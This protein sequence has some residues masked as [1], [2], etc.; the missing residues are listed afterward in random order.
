M[1]V[2]P[3]SPDRYNP[4]LDLKTAGQFW[5]DVISVRQGVPW[6]KHEGKTMV[7]CEFA[8][9]DS[10]HP[11]LKGKRASFLVPESVYTDPADGSETLLMGFARSMGFEDFSKPFDPVKEWHG[12]RFYIAVEQWSDGKFVVTRAAAPKKT[13][14]AASPPPPPV[15]ASNDTPAGEIPF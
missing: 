7:R 10:R 14:A 8:I 5:A 4:E 11:Q 1:A 13:P 15:T 9:N 2:I 12:R 6:N 3:V